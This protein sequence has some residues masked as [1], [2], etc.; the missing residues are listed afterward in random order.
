MYHFLGEINFLF[1]TKRKKNEKKLC[2]SLHGLFNFEF[3][4]QTK[5]F[6]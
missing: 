3:Y 5:M 1:Y 6:E 2:S 4:I